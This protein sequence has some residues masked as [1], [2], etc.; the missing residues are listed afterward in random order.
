[1]KTIILTLAALVAAGAVSAAPAAADTAGCVTRAEYRAVHKGYS[2]TRVHRIFDTAGKR[3]AIA[4]SG[5]YGSQIR[6]Y[7]TCSRFSAV[8]VSFFRRPGGIWRMDAKSAV[9]VS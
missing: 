7:R 1:M 8:S 2:M 3:A 9:W 4:T 5:G 6:S